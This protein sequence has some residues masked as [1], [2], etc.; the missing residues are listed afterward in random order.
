MVCNSFLQ[1]PIYSLVRV[2][3]TNT[4]W[5]FDFA[6]FL[7]QNVQIF[8]HVINQL[9]YTYLNFHLQKWTS[10]F[11]LFQKEH[12][13]L[14]G[15]DRLEPLEWLFQSHPELWDGCTDDLGHLLIWN[16]QFEIFPWGIKVTD[17]FVRTSY[18]IGFCT[19]G[20]TPTSTT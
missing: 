7:L 6:Y 17:V 19:L 15:S 9:G 20:C 8:H 5:I 12:F 18:V 11:C 4:S 1:S 14:S 2:M 13:I 10:L 3:S 16:V